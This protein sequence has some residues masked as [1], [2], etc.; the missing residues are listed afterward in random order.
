[1]SQEDPTTIRPSAGVKI[2]SRCPACGQ[3]PVDR[4][5]LIARVQQLVEKI[6]GLE[7]LLD[8]SQENFG[9]TE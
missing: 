6:E 1:M 4:E 7:T 2:P 9:G 5:V 3:D 8:V